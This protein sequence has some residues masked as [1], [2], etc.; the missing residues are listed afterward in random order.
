MASSYGRE[1]VMDYP[2]PLVDIDSQGNLS[3]APSRKA[4]GRVCFSTFRLPPVRGINGAPHGVHAGGNAD[5]A[6]ETC[7]TPMEASEAL[8]ASSPTKPSPS[9]GFA[10]GASIPTAC[11][12]SATNGSHLTGDTSGLL[13]CAQIMHVCADASVRVQVVQ[14]HPHHRGILLEHGQT[15]I[16]TD[17]DQ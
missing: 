9:T 12:A 10:P 1:S 14:N 11:G 6:S 2:A 13:K 3:L 8:W 5:E 16:S 4:L 17:F 7:P 15:G